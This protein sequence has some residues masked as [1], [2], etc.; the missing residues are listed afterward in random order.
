VKSLI[1]FLAALV[2]ALFVPLLL[3]RLARKPQG[4]GGWPFTVRKPLSPVEQ[5]FFYRLVQ[6]LPGL[7]VLAQVPLSRFLR[8]RK[9]QTW[10]E[11]HDRISQKRIDYLICERDF[12]IVAA[13]ELDDGSHD[14][15]VRIKGDA[16]KTRAL[17]A[18][19]IPFIRW[20]ATALPDAETI[21][22]IV[23]DIRRDRSDASHRTDATRIEPTLA[24]DRFEASND[25]TMFNE[26]T[27]Q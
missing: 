2:F 25:P 15:A 6:T 4:D 20:R 10:S 21:R 9:G 8:V 7:I 22:S 24:V 12:A 23:D 18:A 17:A 26:E 5:I 13:I 3:N 14:G 27:R 1:F 16:V 11:W 19:R